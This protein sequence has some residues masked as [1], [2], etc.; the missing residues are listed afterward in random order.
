MKISKI[1]LFKSY[2]LK[3]T[4]GYRGGISKRDVQSDKPVYKLSSNENLLGSSPMALAAMRK[5]MIGI[6]EYPDPT[7][8][9]LREA[10]SRFY[11]HTIDST[12]FITGNSGVSLLQ[13]IVNAFLGEGLECICSTPA[14][15]PYNSFP[16]MVGAK[17]VDVPLK[18]E[19]FALDLDGIVAAVNE[20]TRLIWLCSP[21]NPTGTHIPVQQVEQLLSKLPEYVVVI[22]DEVYYQY[23][24]A[25]DYSTAVPFVLKG[26]N[27]IGV[28]SFSKA[29]GLAGLRIGYA[30]STPEIA[31]YVNK[32]KRPFQINSLSYEA[33]IAALEDE[34]FIQD[35]VKVVNEGKAYLYPE[36]DDLNLKYWPSQANFILVKP[37]MS[38]KQFHDALI[39]EGIMVRPAEGF[40]LEGY[41]RITI[42]TRDANRALVSALKVVLGKK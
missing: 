13:L 29:Y 17:V 18:A 30:Y 12:Q 40:G 1:E 7:D 9:K 41:V 34:Q 15:T 33:A 38:S 23:V 21:N 42:G 31:T 2:L 35:T 5:A 26:K 39:K 11:D 25:Q 32:L 4:G 28:N 19:S 3:L 8:F 27:V 24:N 14:F 6:N 20:N 16:S 37:P 36:L 10:L 22:Y